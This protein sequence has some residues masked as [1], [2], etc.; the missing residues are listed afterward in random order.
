[1]DSSCRP[2]LPQSDATSDL[3]F[4][5]AIP[6]SIVGSVLSK[7]SPVVVI[8]LQHWTWISVT[9]S[10]VQVKDL[11]E[12]RL[13]PQ[14][15]EILQVCFLIVFLL[16]PCMYN[17]YNNNMAHSLSETHHFGNVKCQLVQPVKLA[18]APCETT[19]DVVY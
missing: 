11:V 3:C 8:F 16:P 10:N 15:N 17:T 2:Q 18:D 9:L 13:K 7:C 5:F 14:W 4:L 1:M 19:R 12:A 6:H